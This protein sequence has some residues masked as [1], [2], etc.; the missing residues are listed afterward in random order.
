[1]PERFADRCA[2]RVEA[3]KLEGA[4]RQFRKVCETSGVMFE[5]R[6]REHY[7][8]PSL[9]R[10][11]RVSRCAEASS[12][13]SEPDPDEPNCTDEHCDAC[14]SKRMIQLIDSLSYRES[15]RLFVA[16]QLAR[17]PIRCAR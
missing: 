2:V 7:E 6:R 17:S 3:S 8:P 5:L 15:E 13:T 4:L 9:R 16:A 10:K 11:K 1:V 12:M 14:E